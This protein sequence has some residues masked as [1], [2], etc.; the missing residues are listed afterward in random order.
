[1]E[2]IC[3][4]WIRMRILTYYPSHAYPGCCVYPRD[5]IWCP[6]CWYS[7]SFAWSLICL[8][9]IKEPAV[10]TG[11]ELTGMVVLGFG[12][13]LPD[14]AD[15]ACFFPP[16]PGLPAHG[17]ER[18][19]WIYCLSLNG[20][21]Y[22][23]Q[24]LS[25]CSTLLPDLVSS[26]THHLFCVLQNLT[27]FCPQGLSWSPSWFMSFLWTQIDF[28]RCSVMVHSSRDQKSTEK[29]MSTPF[30]IA[31]SALSTEILISTA[32]LGQLVGSVRFHRLGAEW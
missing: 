8:L 27:A 24:G 7:W 6:F 23:S 31:M 14:P 26:R 16:S 5:V 12:L 2:S 9:A 1:M 11:V 29:E 32:S 25:L 28:C 30:L 10:H 20:S 4:P 21:L 18:S 22:H 13:P 17:V 19:C 15:T 3:K